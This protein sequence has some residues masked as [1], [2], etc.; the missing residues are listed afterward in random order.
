MT[1]P[2]GQSAPIGPLAVLAFIAEIGM[3]VGLAWAGWGRGSSL[4]L[5]VV[6]AIALPAV[7]AV[8]WGL[9]CAPRSRHR[10]ATPWR[11]ALKVTLFSATVVLL[12]PTE[13]VPAAGIYG[14]VVWLVFLISLPADRTMV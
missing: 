13:P 4:L 2:N 11:W 12:L 3:L 10:L 5:S 8:V 7:A 1:E 6:L 14:V 9:W